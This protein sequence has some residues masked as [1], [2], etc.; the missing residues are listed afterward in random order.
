MGRSLEKD[1]AFLGTGQN[2]NTQILARVHEII[3]FSFLSK[4]EDNGAL[5]VQQKFSPSLLGP[6]LWWEWR[7][8]WATVA[9]F[10]SIIF[11][12]DEAQEAGPG[13]GVTAAQ[14]MRHWHRAR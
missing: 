2:Q 4:S 14:T 7:D 5:N 3:I 8:E 10:P 12:L 6:P 9:L 13:V 1:P 11:S